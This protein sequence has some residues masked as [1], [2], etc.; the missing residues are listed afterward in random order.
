LSKNLSIPSLKRIK[1]E[2]WVKNG[3]LTRKNSK[4]ISKVI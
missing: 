2:K 3:G 1:M 4:K